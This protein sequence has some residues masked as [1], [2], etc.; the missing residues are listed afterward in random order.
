[1][2]H[3]AVAKNVWDPVEAPGED[4]AEM[5]Y[6]MT[7]ALAVSTF[8]RQWLLQHEQCLGCTRPSL[9]EALMPPPESANTFFVF[10]PQ[11]NVFIRQSQKV[12]MAN[13]AQAVNVISPISEYPSGRP[14]GHC[15]AC[16]TTTC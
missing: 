3:P 16:R 6:T 4:G 10:F 5:K 1:M 8:V 13:I 14:R 9:T 12:T 2:G 15:K 7:D 11:L